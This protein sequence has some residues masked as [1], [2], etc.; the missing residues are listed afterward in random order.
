[1]SDFKWL[2]YKG[3]IILGCIRWYCKY[4]VSYRDLKEMML[5]LGI[6]VDHTTLNRWVLKYAPEMERRLRW[7]YRRHRE[8]TS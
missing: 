6:E 3:G 2:H 1:M 7:Y 8:Y 4:K 5:E